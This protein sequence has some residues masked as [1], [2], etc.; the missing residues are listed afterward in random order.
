MA[1][2]PRGDAQQQ[3]QAWAADMSALDDCAAGGGG[4][5]GDGGYSDDDDGGGGD[6]SNGGDGGYDSGG[7]GGGG[8]DGGFGGG[9]AGGDFGDGLEQDPEHELLQAPRRVAHVGVSYS[10][11]SKQVDVHALKDIIWGGVL[12]AGGG[13]GQAQVGLEASGAAQEAAEQPVDFRDVI[14][15]VPKESPAGRLEDMSVHM[16]FICLLHLANQHGL[17]VKSGDDLRTLTVRGRPQA[18]MGG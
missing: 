2:Q 1:A 17:E 7:E 3:H 16:C 5:H 4:A 11:A 12:R 10:R 18:A 14:K 8:W 9:A 13:D 6:Y 15:V